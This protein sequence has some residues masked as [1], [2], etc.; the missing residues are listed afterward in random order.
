[1]QETSTAITS[2]VKGTFN[3]P[4][5]I[6]NG[7]FIHKK[8]VYFWVHSHEGKDELTLLATNVKGFSGTQKTILAEAIKKKT[9][10]SFEPALKLKTVKHPDKRSVVQSEVFKLKYL[11]VSEDALSDVLVAVP[12]R[13]VMHNIASGVEVLYT[14]KIYNHTQK[15]PISGLTKH[16]LLECREFLQ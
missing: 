1:M 4:Q 15:L 16:I 3:D 13:D 9:N 11:G 5:Y 14:V 2:K 12:L 7:I 10:L 8:H 6:L